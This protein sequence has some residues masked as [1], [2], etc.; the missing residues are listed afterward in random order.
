MRTMAPLNVREDL[1][2]TG[3]LRI[4]GGLGFDG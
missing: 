2:I 4:I 1:T 3:E